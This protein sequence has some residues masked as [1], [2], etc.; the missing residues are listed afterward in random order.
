MWSTLSARI[1]WLVLWATLPAVLLVVYQART[2]RT[3]AIAAAEER[4]LQTLQSVAGTQQ[5]L[6]QNTR[7]FL[8]QLAAMPQ[9]HD[10]A[11][12]QCGRYLAEVLSLN[13]TYVNI[14]VPRADGQLLCNARPL[15][16]PVNV[17]NRPYFQQT[18]S[19][20]R[21]PM[22]S[23]APWCCRPRRGR[24]S[25]CARMAPQSWWRSSHS[26]RRAV[27]PWLP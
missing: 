25:A 26:S 19:G 1:R 20:L 4:A 3:D 18:I 15:K 12:P 21:L 23:S 22:A 10:P 9:V 11:A 13:T 16:A 17:A 7:Q 8:Q 24:A 27:N 5:R 14:G 2:H 6:I